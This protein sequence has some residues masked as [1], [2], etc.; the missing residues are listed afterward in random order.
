MIS[1][2]I[3]RSVHVVIR[4]AETDGSR[5]RDPQAERGNP[6]EDREEGSKEPEESR[7]SQEHGP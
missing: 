2:Y 4:G 6:T 3:H 7:T 1:C 5:C